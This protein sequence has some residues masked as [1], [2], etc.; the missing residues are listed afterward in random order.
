MAKKNTE[1]PAKVTLTHPSGKFTVT[2]KAR[3][4]DALVERGYTREGGSKASS[5]SSGLSARNA[6]V[7]RAKELGVPA[8]GSNAELAAAI[9]AA[10]G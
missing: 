9:E 7:A 1:A 8:K 3:R 4:A 6:L 10:G 5:D 2:V